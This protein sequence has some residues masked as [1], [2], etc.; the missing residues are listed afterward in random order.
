MARDDPPGPP[1]REKRLLP[2]CGGDRIAA[3]GGGGDLS[4][5]HALRARGGPLLAKGDRASSLREG[6][7]GGE[8]DPSPARR[9]REGVFPCPENPPGGDPP[10]GEVLAG[11]AD[12]R[13]PRGAR[14]PGGRHRGD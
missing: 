8:A 4:E 11:G 10:D 12:H 13:A 3:W 1:G 9:T 7:G 6:P 2:A 5:G 14:P